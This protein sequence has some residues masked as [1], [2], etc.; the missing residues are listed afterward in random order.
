[1]VDLEEPH[2]RSQAARLRI[3]NPARVPSLNNRALADAL[4]SFHETAYNP[5]QLIHV[6]AFVGG[7]SQL[8]YARVLG[9]YTVEGL[10]TN[11]GCVV[12]MLNL[13]QA[14]Y[15]FTGSQR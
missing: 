14:S 6:D 8:P 12:R 5:R 11:Q 1:M 13:V 10:G 9:S 4:R 15:G 2:H 3:A 7:S